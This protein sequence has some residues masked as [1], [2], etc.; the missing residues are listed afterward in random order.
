MSCDIQCNV[1]QGALRYIYSIQG[2][3]GMIETESSDALNDRKWHDV[4]IMRLSDGSYYL[5]VDDVKYANAEVSLC[6]MQ[7]L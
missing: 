2:A 6:S 7:C 5:I 1:L 3:T 4:V